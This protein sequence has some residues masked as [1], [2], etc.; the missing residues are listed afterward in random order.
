MNPDEALPAQPRGCGGVVAG[1]VVAGG[2]VTIGGDVVAVVDAKTTVDRRRSMDPSY[3]TISLREVH[4]HISDT[5]HTY[6]D[7]ADRQT[8]KQKRKSKMLWP[9]FKSPAALTKAVKERLQPDP[10]TWT[11]H[12]VQVLCACTIDLETRTKAKR[13]EDTSDVQSQEECGRRARK[14][15]PL[16][17]SSPKLHKAPQLP[18]PLAAATA[19]TDPSVTNANFRNGVSAT[20]REILAMLATLQASVDNLCVGV[21]S[22]GH[23]L[24]SIKSRMRL[25]TPGAISEQQGLLDDVNL[26]VQTMEEFAALEE[27]LA[28]HNE[29]M[30]ALVPLKLNW[31]G[32]V[33]W[34]CAEGQERT[35]FCPTK[36][37]EAIRNQRNT[38]PVARIRGAQVMPCRMSG[39]VASGDGLTAGLDETQIKLLQEECILI[40][41]D[42]KNIGSASKKT[43][44]L[45][46]NINK[47][48]LHRAFS[49]FL[50]N[51]E[52]ELLLQ[53]RSDAKITYPAHWTNTC[54][55]H[56]LSV[57][58]ELE[59]A[60]TLGVRRAAQRKLEHELGIIP[61]QVPVDDFHYLTRIHYKSDNVPADGKWGEHE[62]DYI[63][64]MQRSVTVVPNENEV[65]THR[66]V[67]R[68]ELQEIMA[69]S[70]KNG[71]LITP[72][73]RLIVETF[74]DKW[75]DNLRDLK[76]QKDHA[77]IHRMI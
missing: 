44:H 17:V 67:S 71:T 26:S 40:D 66:Y 45:L 61:E 7:K 14:S 57:T 20:E 68:E 48:M 21:A 12:N 30:R 2:V 16:P 34:R 62:I 27:R 24:A 3:T 65:K 22:Q 1:G 42:D 33:G 51:P 64:F 25:L 49:V 54:C 31:L 13:A 60:D 75:W 32:K 73:F 47:G 29:L 63:L 9:L 36:L 43:C 19:T 15:V 52:G 18:T 6:I 69:S 70:Q 35:A 77:T 23:E 59:E 5:P 37:C 39:N 38:S 4:R 46:E 41:N 74:L 50:F 11:S 56:P 28:A 72:W 10:T 58:A 53:Q 8:G 55:S 76:S